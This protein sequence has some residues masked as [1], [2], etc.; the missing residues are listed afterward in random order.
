MDIGKN[1]ALFAGLLA[2]LAGPVFAQ[3]YLAVD[4]GFAWASDE[5]FNLPTSPNP[6]HPT[7]FDT[8]YVFALRGGWRF[9]NVGMGTPRVE[10]EYAWRDNDVSDFGAEGSVGPGTGTLKAN[11]WMVNALFDFRFRSRFV[12][13]AGF[14]LGSQRVEANDIRRDISDPAC[15]TAII[16]GKDDSGAWQAIA[17]VAF[18][19]TPQ[20]AVTLDYRYL[21]TF[22]DVQFG[23]KAGCVPDGSACAR[24]PGQTEARYTSQTLSIGLRY[25]F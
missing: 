11:G 8:G 2:V 25:T 23:Y 19:A 18:E 6:I 16:N 15:C 20:L 9:G 14:G 10:F 13:Y 12:P 1:S 24:L 21:Q 7:S 17:G 4:G 5:D 22:N 3:P